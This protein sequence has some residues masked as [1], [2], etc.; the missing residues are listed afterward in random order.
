MS[1]KLIAGLG[2]SWALPFLALAQSGGIS[3]AIETVQRWVGDL[4]PILIGIGVLYFL[5]G[6]I[7]YMTAGTD[8]EKRKDGISGMAY[9]V[10]AVFI[11]VSIW[12]LVGFISSTTSIEQEQTVTIPQVPGL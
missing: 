2:A 7:K 3:G 9:G 8:S 1:K 6:V 12:G 10:L 5:W 11:M 4:I